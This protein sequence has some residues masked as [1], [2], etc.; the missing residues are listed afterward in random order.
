[1]CAIPN[2][3]KQIFTLVSKTQGSSRSLCVFHRIGERNIL[4]KAQ[5]PTSNPTSGP[6]PFQKEKLY[7]VRPDDR[8]LL[9]RKR[10]ES[11]KKSHSAGPSIE[12]RAAP[13]QKPM[14]AARKSGASIPYLVSKLRKVRRRRQRD[15][16]LRLEGI[17]SL[18]ILKPLVDSWKLES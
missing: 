9:K 4:A 17:P 16:A 1:M 7:T 5:M 18:R 10:S 2:C 15:H 6:R 13:V 14:T 3:G 8:P 12:S 11:G